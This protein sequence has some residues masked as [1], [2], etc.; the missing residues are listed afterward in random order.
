MTSRSR[1][2]TPHPGSC[3]ADRRQDLLRKAFPD[4]LRSTGDS[5]CPISGSS[6]ALLSGFQ[7]R[8]DLGQN[9]SLRH[10]SAQAQCNSPTLATVL[11]SQPA[12]IHSAYDLERSLNPARRLQEHRPVPGFLTLEIR[13]L[14]PVTHPRKPEKQ[15]EPYDG[16]EDH[17]A[18]TLNSNSTPRRM[19]VA[20]YS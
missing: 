11:N 1:P 15:H 12:M 16:S 2:K 7:S 20:D 5:F 13:E 10:P 19:Q 8:P 17:C 3:G 18:K 9:K 14:V 4:W 6:S